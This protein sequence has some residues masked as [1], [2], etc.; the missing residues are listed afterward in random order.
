LGLHFS[1]WTE[2]LP[3]GHRDAP[4]GTPAIKPVTGGRRPTKIPY[5]TPAVEE[6]EAPEDE[7]AR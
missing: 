5:E 7:E 3:G 2:D 1:T 6:R 4:D